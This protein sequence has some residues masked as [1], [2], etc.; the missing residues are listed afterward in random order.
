MIMAHPSSPPSADRL[1]PQP[2]ETTTT[3]QHRPIPGMLEDS[4]RSNWAPPNQ[5]RNPDATRI[6]SHSID[7]P[8]AVSGSS[9]YSTTVNKS[10]LKTGSQVPANW[11]PAVTHPTLA[12]YSTGSF[13]LETP[14][15]RYHSPNEPSSRIEDPRS[16]MYT[17]SPT[18]WEQ[19]Q[20]DLESETLLH[21]QTKID[22]NTREQELN[23]LIQEKDQELDYFRKAW[24]QANNELNKV[25]AQGQGFYQVTDNEL[26][27]KAKVLRFNI[28]N[29]ADQ[30]FVGESIDAKSSHSFSK[31]IG[32]HVD[33]SHDV[34][35]TCMK[36][37][38]RRAIIIRA[39][40]WAT[41]TKD[42]FGKFRWA[43]TH[44]SNSMYRLEDVL[45]K[46]SLVI[47]S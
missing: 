37:S 26:I 8:V 27:Q 7:S 47:S 12:P 19:L 42:I 3:A 25:L 17:T 41:L 10:G 6:G 13:G 44:V 32:E 2:M 23:K 39:Y 43:G 15:K 29:F 5:I 30:Q 31:S 21:N 36:D 16:I 14:G 46:T 22:L 35:I 11:S 20:Q 45:G 33:I 24:K 38:S 18:E 34:I 28:R 9:D 40:L 4:S 1:L